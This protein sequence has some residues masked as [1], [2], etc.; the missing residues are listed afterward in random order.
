LISL[1]LTGNIYLLGNVRQYNPFND[2][3]AVTSVTH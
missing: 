1:M 2:I 3:R